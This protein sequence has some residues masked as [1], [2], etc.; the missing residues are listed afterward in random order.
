MTTESLAA[1]RPSAKP[2]EF[3]HSID[4]ACAAD[5]AYTPHAATMIRSALA[6][7]GPDLHVHFLHGHDLPED[8]KARLE[9]MVIG[10]DASISFLPITPWEVE[11]LPS[12]SYIPVTMWYRVFLPELRPQL[13]RILY[14]DADT[15]VVD[16][17]APLWDE[18]LR[19]HLAGAVTNVFDRTVPDRPEGFELERSRPPYFNSGVLLMNLELMRKERT[20]E[21]LLAFARAQLPDAGWPD[22]DAL[23]HVLGPKRKPLHPRWNLMN[24]FLIYPWSEE[25]FGA[26]ALAEAREDPAIRHFEGPSINKPWH[27]LCQRELWDL[28]RHHRRQT[29]WPRYRRAGMTPPNMVRYLARRWVERGGVKKA[30]R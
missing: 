16:S 21:A 1:V 2:S 30:P 7:H 14:L 10:D 29:P 28:Y 17:L 6:V 19:G 26:Q 11:G 24:S 5:E 22:Q 23:N 12:W 3:P 27:L 25:T 9:E 20:T 4:I 13:D 8:S 15:L 18:D